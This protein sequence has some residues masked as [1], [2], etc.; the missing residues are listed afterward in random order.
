MREDL[1]LTMFVGG[2]A[3]GYLGWYAIFWYWHRR[4][5]RLSRPYEQFF[6][7]ILAISCVLVLTFF[8][9]VLFIF[10]PIYLFL[11]PKHTWTAAMLHGTLA[12]GIL[13]GAIAAEWIR[14]ILNPPRLRT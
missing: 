2:C 8:V 10:D 1:S 4:E 5:S 9:V 3:I 6:S 13:F 14:Y 11:F 12:L 7:S